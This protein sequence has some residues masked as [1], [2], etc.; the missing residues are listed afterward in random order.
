MRRKG[1]FFPTLIM[2]PTSI[3]C[4]RHGEKSA[5]G[6]KMKVNTTW[7]EKNKIK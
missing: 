4:D 2:H 1:L 6:K 7:I 5:I 3:K